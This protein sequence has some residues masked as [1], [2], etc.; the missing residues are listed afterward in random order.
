MA[1]SPDTPTPSPICTRC[2]W[3][4]DHEVC[5][6]CGRTRDE[7]RDEHCDPTDRKALS[8]AKEALSDDR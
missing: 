2:H 8:A 7:V 1:A 3:W 5:R 4:A 6:R